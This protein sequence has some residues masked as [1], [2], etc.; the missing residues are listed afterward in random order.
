LPNLLEP[1]KN[2]KQKA[3]GTDGK[4]VTQGDSDFAICLAKSGTKNQNQPEI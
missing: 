1:A 2:E 3:T 4:V